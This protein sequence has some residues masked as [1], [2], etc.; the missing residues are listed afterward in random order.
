MYIMNNIYE[1][2]RC[3]YNTDKRSSITNHMN[4][5][6][7]CPKKLDSF[8]YTDKEIYDLS[9]LKKCDRQE[10]DLK[11]KFCNK[12]YCN[13][14]FLEK[15]IKDFC[16]N[17]N[18]D[19]ANNKNIEI[20]NI[21]QQNC[22]ITNNN[23][24]DITNNIQNT[25]I[26]NQNIYVFNLP[27]LP[28]FPIPFDKEWSTDHI[29]IYLKYALYMTNHKFTELL[30]SLLENDSNLNVIMDKDDN[31]GY[32]YNSDNKYKNMEKSEIANLS[33]E[34]LF[35]QLNKIKE[36]LFKDPFFQVNPLKREFFISERK[37]DD[38]INDL[39]MQ[40]NVQK[41]INDIYIKKRDEAYKIY[42]NNKESLN[43]KTEGF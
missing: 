41:C 36:E 37:Y 15:H 23:S 35:N 12:N 30:K 18:N 32:V 5:K 17:K 13:K 8:N 22:D 33:M 11:C 2:M 42:E 6:L 1:C 25:I 38:F 3:G 26:E 21:T 4:R 27:N 20:N 14:V 9:L 43:N 31:T 28:N 7:K 16:K 29:N 10:S 34:K 24:C 19:T 40:K 39:E